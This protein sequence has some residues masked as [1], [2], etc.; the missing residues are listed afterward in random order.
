LVI[1]RLYRDSDDVVAASMVNT[2]A[3]LTG[4]ADIAKFSRVHRTAQSRIGLVK[5]DEFEHG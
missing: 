4:N 3:I 2:F 5:D 1:E